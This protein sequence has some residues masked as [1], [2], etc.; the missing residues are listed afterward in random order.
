MGCA[1]EQS[2]C[3]SPGSVS[4]LLRVPPP[5]VWA[6]SITVT[7]TPRTAKAAAQAR[8]LGPAPTTMAELMGLST[9]WH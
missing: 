3:S 4:S 5:M 2:S 9:T 6:A 8:P 1:A 7:D